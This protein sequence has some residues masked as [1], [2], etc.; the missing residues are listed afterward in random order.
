M[1]ERRMFAKTIIDSD[2]F[3][4]MP[5]STQCLYFHLNMRADDD[6]FLNNPKKIQRMIGASADD[7]NLLV[8]KRFILA[9]EEGIIVI[10]HWRM[11][12][13]IRKDRYNQTQYIEQLNQLSIQEDGSYTERLLEIASEDTSRPDDIPTDNQMAYQQHP[14]VRLGKDSIG[15]GSIDILPGG[16]TP[17]A[18]T[19]PPDHPDPPKPPKEEKPKKPDS[20]V[21]IT[22][23]LND[24]TEYPVRQDDVDAWKELYQAVDVLQELRKM[25]GWSEANPKKRKTKNGIK[26]FINSWLAGEQ[27]KYHGPQGGGQSGGTPQYPRNKYG[28]CI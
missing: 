20:P 23:L 22:I 27:D 16:E 18:P 1:A 6:G 7:L 28:T 24:G 3:L 4:D 26:R 21:V 8:A 9:F 19:E 2:A 5:L 17:P 13:W 11:H 12:N 14:Q 15:K 25:K 10:K